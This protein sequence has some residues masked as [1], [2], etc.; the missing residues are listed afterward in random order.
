VEFLLTLW[1][2]LVQ[3][4]SSPTDSLLTQIKAAGQLR[5]A[6]RYSAAGEIVVDG[7]ELELARRFAEE[8]EVELE[9][10]PVEDFIEIFRQVHHQVVHFAAPGLSV[11]DEYQAVIRFGPSYQMV[12]TQIIQRRGRQRPRD[13]AE[14]ADLSKTRIVGSGPEH[15]YRL[16]R[17]AEKHPALRWQAYPGSFG[18]QLL[19]RL[20]AREL[21]YALVDAHE[22]DLAREIYPE[23][24]VAL[25]LPG[26][27]SLAWAFPRFGEDDS[28]YLAAIRFFDRQRRSGEMARLIDR[29]HG[30]GHSLHYVDARAFHRHI[31]ERLPLYQEHFRA[32]AQAHDLDWR[33]LA[34]IGYQESH[35]NPLAVSPTGV[36]GLMML[37]EATATDTGVDDRH[38]AEASIA[39]GAKHFAVLKKR[40]PARISEPD[41]TWMALAAY[42]L[43]LGHVLDARKLARRDGADPD[44]WVDVR[45]YVGLLSQPYW[46]S[47]TRHGHARGHEGLHF[48]RNVRKFY[49]ILLSYDNN[50]ALSHAPETFSK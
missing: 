14:L 5:V 27:Q 26:T 1:F 21:D 7:L 6:T 48:V 18:R 37:T 23:L 33:L 24:E 44:R 43:G 50:R 10:V 9:I 12:E 13:L 3:I 40:L 11:D 29:Y 15:L 38:D 46:Y 34:A 42:N 8:L 4:F 32:E 22:F 2:G 20:A 30:S 28:L 39:G 47:Q 31:A 17:L 35:W 19:A 36:R 25:T 41:R 49:D 16:A 45:P